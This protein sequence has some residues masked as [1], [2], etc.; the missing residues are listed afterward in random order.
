LE[1]Q[2]ETVRILIQNK[3]NVN[4]QDNDGWTALM[5]GILFNLYLEFKLSIFLFFSVMERSLRNSSNF[6]PKQ[7]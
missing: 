6:D 4:L 5:L 2:L 3:A 1:G 7:S